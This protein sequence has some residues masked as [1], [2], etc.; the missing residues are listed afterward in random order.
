MKKYLILLCLLSFIPNIVFGAIARDSFTETNN[1]TGSSKTWAHTISGSNTVLLVSLHTINDTVTGVTYNSVSMTQL[2]KNTNIDGRYSYVYGLLNP[3]TGTNNVVASFSGS[4]GSY[5]N[6]VSYNGVLQSGLPDA[7]TFVNRTSVTTASVTVT[8]VADNDAIVLFNYDNGTLATAGANTAT[9]TITSEA[10]TGVALW[11]SSS[12]SL[13]P[14]GA[15]TLNLN[16]SPAFS[17]TLIGVALAP[18]P[19]ATTRGE[20]YQII[21]E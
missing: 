19:P 11:E 4:V 20:E 14:A 10:A 21:F 12:L 7:Y 2:I 16:H 17:C 18:A 6:S 13:T 15:Y 5:T 8:T 9:T 3:T 1:A